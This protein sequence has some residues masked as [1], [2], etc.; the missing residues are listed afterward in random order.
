M[1]WCGGILLLAGAAMFATPGPARAQHSGG[2]R[3]GGAHFSAGQV[4]GAQF[5][6]YHSDLYRGGSSYG[7][8]HAYNNSHYGRY[9]Y[10]PYYYGSF[11]YLP[12][13]LAYDSGYYDPY[14]DEISP[15]S[16]G[17]AS[18]T[19]PDADYR[20]YRP[21]VVVT[22]DDELSQ[23]DESVHVTVRVPAE[24]EIWFQG[25]KMTQTGTVREYQSPPLTPGRPVRLRGSGPLERERAR[26]DPDAIG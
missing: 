23:P 25:T 21:P 8:P 15:P 3:S 18:A 26:G 13:G 10:Y 2:G 7:S 1:Y 11:P 17:Y 24:A 20:G 14:S 16:E 19:S 12:S 4:G 6:G 5:G 9:G 22:P